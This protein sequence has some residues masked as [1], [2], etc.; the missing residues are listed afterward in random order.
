MNAREI[1][2]DSVGPRLAAID[3]HSVQDIL[4]ILQLDF[5]ELSENSTQADIVKKVEGAVR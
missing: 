1:N 2:L 4:T 3:A 5:P